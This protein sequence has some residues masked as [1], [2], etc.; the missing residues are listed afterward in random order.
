M[1]IDDVAPAVDDSRRLDYEREDYQAYRWWPVEDV[2]AG[3]RFYPG[4]PPQYLPLL[5]AGREVDEPF[6]FAS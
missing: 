5:L 3:G 4:R 6:E 1:R 2:V